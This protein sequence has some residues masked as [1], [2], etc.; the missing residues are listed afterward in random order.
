MCP[1]FSL[2]F[3]FSVVFFSFSF[4]GGGKGGG[5]WLTTKGLGGNEKVSVPASAITYYTA[6]YRIHKISVNLEVGSYHE[7]G[8]PLAQV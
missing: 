8:N 3:P 6:D 7:A 4:A 1:P 2:P 5:G